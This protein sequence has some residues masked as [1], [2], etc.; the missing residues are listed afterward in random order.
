MSDDAKFDAKAS[1]ESLAFAWDREESIDSL[2]LR[3]AAS[4]PEEWI[5]LAAWLMREARVDEVW[6]FLKPRD[7]ADRFEVLVPRLGRR[8]ELWVYLVNTWRELGRI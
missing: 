6:K 3:L 7:I 1:A 8:R 4:S 5:E 2:R